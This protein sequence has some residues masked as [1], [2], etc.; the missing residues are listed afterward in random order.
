M[1]RI[2]V[3]MNNEYIL[4]LRFTGN[5]FLKLFSLKR[6]PLQKNAFQIIYI[7]TVFQLKNLMGTCGEN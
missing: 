5:F 1:I 2:S 4:I 7:N 3:K 6:A